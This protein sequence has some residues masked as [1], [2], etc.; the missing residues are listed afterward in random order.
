MEHIDFE[1][2]DEVLTE[3]DVVSKFNTVFF[4]MG[5][6]CFKWINNA[7]GLE[8]G[9]YLVARK[10]VFYSPTREPP[11]NLVEALGLSD[12]KDFV[13]ETSKDWV[14]ETLRNYL[15]TSLVLRIEPQKSD[16]NKNERDKQ[17][18]KEIGHDLAK[19]VKEIFD[20]ETR[21]RPIEKDFTVE[22]S[23]KATRWDSFEKKPVE[24]LVPIYTTTFTMG[25]DL[26]EQ[27]KALRATLLHRLPVEDLTDFINEVRPGRT[28]SPGDVIHALMTEGVEVIFKK[29]RAVIETDRLT[30]YKA[31]A[32]VD[33]VTSPIFNRYAREVSKM[34]EGLYTAIERGLIDLIGS[35]GELEIDSTDEYGRGTIR[36]KA[37]F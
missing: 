33:A 31:R 28:V 20:S 18:G 2:M 12:I 29:G 9:T 3:L 16:G 22:L 13:D 25:E 10:S 15:S 35:G 37:Y 36:M 24:E 30:I 6:C 32:Y 11:L 21:F 23:H 8:P 1:R 27:A 26:K 4:Y 7:P 14:I 19:V 17:K 5:G 34:M